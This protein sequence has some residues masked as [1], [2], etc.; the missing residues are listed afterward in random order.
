M[1]TSDLPAKTV[2]N[3]PSEPSTR[4]GAGIPPPFL[5]LGLFALAIVLIVGAL[6]S[7]GVVRFGSGSQELAGAIISPPFAA[8]DFTLNDQFDQPVSLSQFRGKVVVLTFLYTN[9]PDACPLITEKLHQAYEQLGPDASRTAIL[10]V[11]V[12]PA[13][14]TVP[15]VRAYSVEKDMLNKWHFLVGSMDQ[16]QP[17]WAAYGASSARDDLVVS[18]ANATA[19]AAHLATPTPVPA[20]GYVVDHSAPTFVIDPAGQARAILDVNFAPSDLVQDVRALLK[21]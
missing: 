5:A 17:V 16:V 8:K 10:A 20:G 6:V 21:Q 2:A 18:Q 19:V 3:Q 4:G 13:R 11:T 12:D 1:D 7:F 15:Q 9:C 14:D